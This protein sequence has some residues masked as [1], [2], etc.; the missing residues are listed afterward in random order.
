[1]AIFV[2]WIIITHTIRDFSLL[3]AF[4][5]FDI[6]LLISIRIIITCLHC[7]SSSTQMSQTFSS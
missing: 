2:I 5:K 3:T 7:Y 1:M 4:L 6:I